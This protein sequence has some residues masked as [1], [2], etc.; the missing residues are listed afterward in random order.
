MRRVFSDK[1]IPY[2]AVSYD[3]EYE[4]DEILFLT[5]EALRGLFSYP[6]IPSVDSPSTAL[7]I[8]NNISVVLYPTGVYCP[9]INQTWGQ[10]RFP[11]IGF[12]YTPISMYTRE[13]HL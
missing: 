10:Q 11:F 5:P 12:K 9:S 13:R 3:S 7:V 2:N 6:L 4:G 8:P 1:F